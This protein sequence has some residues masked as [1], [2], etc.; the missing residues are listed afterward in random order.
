LEQFELHK[1]SRTNPQLFRLFGH[2][3]IPSAQPLAQWMMDCGKKMVK[4]GI[5]SQC[6]DQYRLCDWMGEFSGNFKWHTDNNHHGE[7][8]L[9]IAVSDARV[10]GFRPKKRTKSIY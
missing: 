8:I 3:D 9:A 6:P 2:F 5:F 7:K 10:I 4:R 1:Q